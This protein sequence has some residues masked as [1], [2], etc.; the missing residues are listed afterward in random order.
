MIADCR[1]A[2]GDWRLIL[3]LNQECSQS[4]WF[5]PTQQSGIGNRQSPIGN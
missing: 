2:I 3:R 4:A 5:I 1:L